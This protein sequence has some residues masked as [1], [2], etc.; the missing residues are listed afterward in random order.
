MA[1]ARQPEFKGEPMRTNQPV[2]MGQPALGFSSSRGENIYLSE[3][4]KEV[5]W[6]AC[7]SGNYIYAS[8]NLKPTI[9]YSIEINGSGHVDIGIVTVNPE[10]ISCERRHSSFRRMNEVKVHKRKFNFYIRIENNQVI[11]RYNDEEYKINLEREASA[12]IAIYPKFGEI[13]AAIKGDNQMKLSGTHG[14]NIRLSDQDTKAITIHKCPAAIGFLNFTLQ[15]NNQVQLRCSPT[16][17]SGKKPSRFHLRIMAHRNDPETL[18]ADF[19]GTFDTS[20]RSISEPPWTYIDLLDRDVCEA[21]ISVTLTD[22]QSIVCST[23]GEYEKEMSLPFDASGGVWLIFELYR[24][25]LRLL[26][27]SDVKEG[28][29]EEK[30][31]V[32]KKQVITGATGNG[33]SRD[34]MDSI[35]PEHRGNENVHVDEPN[36]SSMKV[37]VSKGPKCRPEL[38]LD[39]SQP[40]DSE[41]GNPID[42]SVIQ[43]GMQRIEKKV[44][45]MI[46]DNLYPKEML[47]PV[48]V[49]PP[50]TPVKLSFKSNFVKLLQDLKTEDV[51]DY[52]F[53]YDIISKN[54][55][56][57]VLAE[58]VPINAN[59]ILLLELL[60]KIVD[61]TVFEKILNDSAHQHLIPLFFPGD[62][63]AKKT[64]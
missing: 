4:L 31:Q 12:W 15:P 51:I 3:D 7:R 11:S 8:Q 53:Q 32:K 60:N 27:L 52:L 24:V 54:L 56:D 19:K 47:S 45:K 25:S 5:S 22:R 1:S 16:S 35:L 17:E 26:G 58:K 33:V 62:T 44:D 49:S 13:T 57:K 29:Q 28:E 59:R 40:R 42:M 23:D 64:V 20:V 38:S 61:R 48:S 14:H 21:A 55:L 39:L 34:E 50:A 2:L 63:S 10:G 6:F 9:V 43:E 46:I 18:L 37:G 41:T 36:N 30:E